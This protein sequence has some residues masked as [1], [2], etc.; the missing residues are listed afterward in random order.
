MIFH[1][2]HIFSTLKKIHSLTVTPIQ[3]KY[4]GILYRSRLEA[5]WSVFFNFLNIAHIYEPEGYK[6]TDGN[7]FVE[8]Y[9]PDFYLPDVFYRNTSQTGWY[10]EV[11]P[12]GNFNKKLETICNGLKRPGLLLAGWQTRQAEHYQHGEYYDSNMEFRICEDCGSVLVGFSYKHC[13][14]QKCGGYASDKPA[15]EAAEVANSY[16]FDGSVLPWPTQPQT[17]QPYP[18]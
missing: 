17:D 13:T 1:F 9:L 10:I 8:Q 12:H 2:E 3:T 5:R 6:V 11:K 18:F 4:N 14:C 16:R 15:I 7:K